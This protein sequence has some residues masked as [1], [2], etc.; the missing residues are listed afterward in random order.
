MDQYR[1]TNEPTDTIHFTPQSQPTGHTGCWTAWPQPPHH[2]TRSPQGARYGTLPPLAK[3][4]AV[5]ARHQ[6]LALAHLVGREYSTT[7]ELRRGR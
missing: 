6:Q 2:L 3:P 5:Q 7:S 4:S 1:P